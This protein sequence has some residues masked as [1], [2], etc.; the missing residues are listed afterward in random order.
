MINGPVV[1]ADNMASFKMREM[2]MVG[3]KK[4][5]GEVIALDGSMGTIQVYEETEG[6]KIHEPVLPTG[7]PLS[8]KLGPGLMGNMFDGIERPLKKIEEI[9][10]GFIGEGIGLISLD[11]QKKWSVR[12][13]VQEG[14]FLESGAIF[15]LVQETEVIEHRLMVA[16][17]IEGAVV[18]CA[19]DGD[20]TME[21]TLLHIEDRHGHIHELKMYQEWPVRRPRPVKERMILSQ[22]LVTGQRVLDIFSPW[23]RVAQQLYPVALGQE[24]P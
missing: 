20:Y 2:V 17:R 4:L 22:P 11:E 13:K 3:H 18:W 8:L 7:K 24:K 21:D 15:A 9:S 12:F 1:K 14:D 5:I 6:L 16:N 19:L 10:K 23:L